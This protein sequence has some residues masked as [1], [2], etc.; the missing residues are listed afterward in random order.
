MEELFTASG[1]TALLTLTVLEIVLGIDNVIFI[2]ILSSKL[3]EHQQAQARQLGIGL[4]VFTR[5]ILLMSITFIMG[6]TAPVVTIFG[7]PLS[8]RDLILLGGGLFLIGKST[9]EIHEKL[10]T[11]EHA[12][13]AESAPSSFNGVI[14]Q[15]VLID[16]VFSLDSVITAVGISGNLW[17]MVPAVVI[18]AIVMV[19]FAGAV[20]RLVEEHPTLKIL[21]LAF[22]ILIGTL[23]VIEGW[24]PEAVH[25]FHLKN[26]VY[27]A[28]AFSVVIEMINMRLRKKSDPVHLHNR[29]HLESEA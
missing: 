23:L 24:N 12:R 13:T 3:P 17:V 20:S 11:S 14:A 4:A 10:E 26:Y 9:Y 25:D 21:A 7:N 5:I 8:V 16:I 29:P 19:I 28:M 6:L 27:F 1:L 18:A 15:I 22:L 2:A